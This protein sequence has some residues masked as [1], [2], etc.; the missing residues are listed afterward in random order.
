MYI[1]LLSALT[2]LRGTVGRSFRPN[3]SLK[4]LPE[5][6]HILKRAV[7]AAARLFYQHQVRLICQQRFCYFTLLLLSNSGGLM[8][9]LVA[10]DV[11]IAVWDLTISSLSQ[12][13]DRLSLS[14]S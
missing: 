13:P 3:L 9:I 11:P 6:P 12:N 2:Q 7:N 8:T 10:P 1:N 4:A 5:I 14:V